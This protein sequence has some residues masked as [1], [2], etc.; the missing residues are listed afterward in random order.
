MRTR[1]LPSILWLALAVAGCGDDGD[2]ASNLAPS[3]PPADASPGG[4]WTGPVPSLGVTLFG[5]VTE[6]GE[7]QLIQSDEAQ[8]F[9]M[10]AVAGN[11]V[12][13]SYAGAAPA[14]FA[15]PDGATTGTG[16][17]TGT[18][19]SRSRV[20]ATT[21]FRTSRGTTTTSSFELAYDRLYERP[22]ALAAVAGNWRDPDTG[23]VLSVNGDG[24]AFSQDPVT[25][26]VINGQFSIV[27]P[28]YNAY[29]ASLAFDSCRGVYA[30]MNGTTARGLGTLDNRFGPD[31]LIVGVANSTAAYAWS[32]Q[33]PRT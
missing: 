30:I 12:T 27:D 23:A 13:S 2:S 22:S 17:L 11:A 20:T 14:G 29:R 7:F 15:F 28:R 32:A 24:V 16:T 6:S 33:F 19:A 10:L 4:I 18:V 21:T 9:G 31:R 3:P 8:Y 5:I 26:C 25:G 1:T